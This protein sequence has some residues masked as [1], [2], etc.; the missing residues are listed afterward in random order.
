[1]MNTPYFPN[2]L[3]SLALAALATNLAISFDAM[4]ER[5]GQHFRYYS[6]L[7]PV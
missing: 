2:K 1:M 6:R 4:E 3:V 7:Q 5:I